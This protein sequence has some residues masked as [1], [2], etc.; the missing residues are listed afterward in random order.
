MHIGDSWLIMIPWYLAYG[1]AGSGSNIDPYTNLY[2][3]LQLVDI[4][5]LGDNIEE[6]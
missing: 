4:T 1:Q 2:F 5:Y 3:R 6:K